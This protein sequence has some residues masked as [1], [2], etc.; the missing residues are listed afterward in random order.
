[1]LAFAIQSAF[2]KPGKISKPLRFSDR[3]LHRTRV[4]SRSAA[5]ACFPLTDFSSNQQQC[6]TSTHK[7]GTGCDLAEAG[8]R[9][10]LSCS[11]SNVSL[12]QTGE[13]SKRCQLL[14]GSVS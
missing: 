3:E 2:T 12:D 14:N 13:A 1:M 5:V 10:F 4:L 9:V 8:P 6:H 7:C 11:S